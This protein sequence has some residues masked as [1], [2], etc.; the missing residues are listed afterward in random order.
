MENN[1]LSVCHVNECVNFIIN[2]APFLYTTLI[3]TTSFNSQPK[4]IDGLNTLHTGKY[5]SM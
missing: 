4:W 5:I 1:L 3:T 2:T